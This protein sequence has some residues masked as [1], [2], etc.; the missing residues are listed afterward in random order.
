MSS[1]IQIRN[2]KICLLK[3]YPQATKEKFIVLDSSS[4]FN[5]GISFVN[6]RKYRKQTLRYKNR[7][8]LCYYQKKEVEKNHSILFMSTS[9][10][11][12]NYV[13]LKKLSV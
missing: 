8:Q 1:W 5:A 2:F 9:A 4:N 10:H 3:G 13:F 12:K 11:T 7:C 6:E